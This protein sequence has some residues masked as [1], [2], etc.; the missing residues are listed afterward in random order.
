[1]PSLDD[2]PL[3]EKLRLLKAKAAAPSQPLSPTSLPSGSDD[4]PLSHRLA[5]LKRKLE[6]S[7]P[8]LEPSKKAKA[9]PEV[10]QKAKKLKPEERGK[11]HKQEDKPVEK[12]PIVDTQS[13]KAKPTKQ[14]TK[15]S[16]PITQSKSKESKS[17]ET[18]CKQEDDKEECDNE[19]EEYKWWEEDK[20]DNSVKWETLE[21]NGPLFPP[22]YQPHGVP[23]IY[24]GQTVHLEPEPEE[25]AGFYA[26][27]LGTDHGDNPV[28]QQNF[29]ADFKQVLSDSHSK[30]T[31]VIRDFDKCD[32]TPMHRHFEV[33]KEQKKA[34]GKE[35]KAALKE[36]RQ[37]QEKRFGFAM[38]DGRREKIGNFRIE[39]PGLF[40]GRGKHPKTG[41][42]KQRV[43]PEQVTI[44]IGHGATIPD[45]PE[46]H[47]W[48]KVIHD[49]TVSW[50]ATWVEN[51]NGA[52]KYVFLAP[53]SSLKGQ[54]D[55]K[56]FETA[57]RLKAVVNK[58]R[59]ENKKELHDK[60]MFVRQRATALW[61]IDH[62]AL[63]A[64]NEKGD[65]EA[66]TVGCC[67]LRL[68][69]VKLVEPS[70]VVFDF[71]GKDSIRYYNEVQVEPIIFKN[72][73]IF[74]RPPK[75]PSDPI[76]DR[77]NTSTLNKYLNKLMDGLTAK[78][79][80]TFNASFTFQVELE[81]TDPQ[82][83]IAEKILAYNRANREVAILCN[84]QRSVP[85]THGQSMERLKDKI[86]TIKYQRHL[87]RLQIRESMSKKDIQASCP[88]A[89]DPESDMDDEM[90]RK[91]ERKAEEARIEKHKKAN[92]DSNSPPPPPSPKKSA[93]SETLCK[94][95]AALSARIH[96]SKHL[97]IDKDEN[98]TTSLGTSK[99]N[100]ID[101][102][103]TAA[104]CA[105]HEVPIEKMF[106]KTL[107]EK[108]KWAM[109][110]KPD[111][112]F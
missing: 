102:R 13:K 12:K 10:T 68:E 95:F 8:V 90:V 18:V 30:W 78:V 33:L 36:V 97:L 49:N 38:L 80:R 86:M 27:L 69:H 42:L 79:F 53:G 89:L 58:I 17:K 72:L 35:E 108:F 28:F 96:A 88:D 100:Y 84:H 70:T 24:D 52:Q 1:M 46:G 112:W 11:I 101:P 98:K 82:A 111:W 21:H 71:L 85:K 64:G 51:I 109:D 34:M 67:S 110:V 87:V 107:R 66:D 4:V 63:R 54:S 26:A 45:P 103:I 56:K 61:L 83:S 60:E 22:P 41:K 16:K 91:K 99:T 15:E 59:K 104:W 62:L 31:S 43:Q 23:M 6:T 32:F 19:E 25:V 29:F 40:R 5:M 65:D 81:K 37:E 20:S 9:E 93:S 7:E 44:N 14:N 47:Q 2:I 57:R 92:P 76:F 106:T 3:A 94:R 105:K 50:L 73:S 74:M 48:G 77:L 55:L 39:P 75:Q